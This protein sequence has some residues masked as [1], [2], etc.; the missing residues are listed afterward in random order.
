M[1]SSDWFTIK[2]KG[3]GTHGSQP[4]LGVDPI[5][6]SAQIIQGLQTIVS[7]QSELT[8]AP[9]VIT[10]GKIQS[11]VRNNIIPD[12]CVMNGTIRTLDSKM[13]KEIHEKIKLTATKIAEAS[14]AVAEVT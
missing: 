3:K 1:A 9:V 2:V 14:N 8:K 7:R 12:E 4:W 6:V 5:V 11:G 10:I 13:Q